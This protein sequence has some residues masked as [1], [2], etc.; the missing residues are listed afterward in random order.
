[1]IKIEQ[2]TYETDQ[3][4][5]P[6]ISSNIYWSKILEITVQKSFIRGSSTAKV[7]IEGDG[8]ASASSSNVRFVWLQELPFCDGPDSPKSYYN[9]FTYF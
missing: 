3:Y 6:Y 1:V 9:P 4:E 8:P 2:L 7:G 5:S